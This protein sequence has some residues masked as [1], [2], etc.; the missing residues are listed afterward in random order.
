MKSGGI[1][2]RKK[3]KWNSNKGM[4]KTVVKRNSKIRNAQNNGKFYQF[5]IDSDPNS[6]YTYPILEVQQIAKGIGF[7]SG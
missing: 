1:K 7:G 6:V 3:E 2:Y 4:K 5:K